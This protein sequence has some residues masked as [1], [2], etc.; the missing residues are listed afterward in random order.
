MLRHGLTGR[1]NP[2][3]PALRPWCHHCQDE[4]DVDVET[5][6]DNVRVMYRE[7]C[8]RCHQ[9]V[10]SGVFHNVPLIGAR[11]LVAERGWAGVQGGRHGTI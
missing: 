7:V 11:D 6:H 4:T 10:A 1:H 8:R 3:Q 9:V 2:F 5:H